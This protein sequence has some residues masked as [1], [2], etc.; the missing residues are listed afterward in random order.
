M[1]RQ[2]RFGGGGR[3]PKGFDGGCGDQCMLI[4]SIFYC[5]LLVFPRRKFLLK[6]GR[7]RLICIGQGECLHD[8]S[9]RLGIHYGVDG[10]SNFLVRIGSSFL[11]HQFVPINDVKFR[12]T[13]GCLFSFFQSTI[14]RRRDIECSFGFLFLLLLVPFHTILVVN[15]AGV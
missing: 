8:F 12:G 3:F 5:S 1:R 14:K 13:G 6:V 2:F 7:R 11:R 15:S 4:F 9:D 10:W